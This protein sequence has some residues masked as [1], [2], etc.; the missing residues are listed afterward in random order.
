MVERTDAEDEVLL[1]P[2][3]VLGEP[4]TRAR[5]VRDRMP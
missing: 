4:S 5:L 1:R 3:T 2:V